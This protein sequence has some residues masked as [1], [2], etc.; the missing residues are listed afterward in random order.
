[1]ASSLTGAH[2]LD[3][4]MYHYVAAWKYCL[5]GDVQ[6]SRRSLQVALEMAEEAGCVF[7]RGIVRAQ[8]GL[9]TYLLG[10]PEAGLSILRTAE[11]EGRYMNTETVLCQVTAAR[12]E[13]AL[14]DGDETSCYEYMSQYIAISKSGGIL[15]RPWWR[16][17]VMSRL[18]ARVLDQGHEVTWVQSLIQRRGLVPPNDGCD[19][20]HW[21][22][23]VKIYALGRFELLVHGQPIRLSGKSKSRQL[24]LLRILIALG[25]RDISASEVAEWLWPD[26]MGDAAMDS[27]KTT[28]IRL[29]RFLRCKEAIRYSNN[30]LTLDTGRYCWVD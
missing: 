25:G 3:H 13:C 1:M 6:A 22:W 21:P 18:L 9:M 11:E 4:S 28:V 29:R 14:H 23:P 30:R 27:L 17:D 19:L 16:A 5:D 2:P 15:N 12:A 7:F 26:A 20:E 24:E 8:L 10:N